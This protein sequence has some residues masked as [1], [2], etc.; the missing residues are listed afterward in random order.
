MCISPGKAI[1]NNNNHITIIVKTCLLTHIYPQS[2]Q[3]TSKLHRAWN[4]TVCCQWAL[5]VNYHPTIYIF[6]TEVCQSCGYCMAGN[7]TRW[8]YRWMW[9]DLYPWEP[10]VCVYNPQP[11]RKVTS[12]M[13]N[14]IPI[15]K[16]CQGGSVGRASDSRSTDLRFEPHQG[17]K[18]NLCQFFRV[19]NAELT[20]CWSVQ[21]P[22]IPMHK[23]DHVHTLKILSP[24]QS[25][26]D[27]RNTKRPSMH[28]KIN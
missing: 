7:W 14:S 28:F 2:F 18:T 22:C 27:Y 6:Y 19:K 26:V 13:C 4:F 8:K 11:G 23:N 16:Q 17:H 3:I 21:P 10:M 5:L 25:L 15:T 12:S 9:M 1:I 24:C 20:C